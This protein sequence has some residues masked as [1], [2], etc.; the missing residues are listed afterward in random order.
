MTDPEGQPKAEGDPPPWEQPG[1]YR[2]DCTPHRGPLLIALSS[3]SFSLARV[4][5]LVCPMASR[6]HFAFSLAICG[7]IALPLGLVAWRLAVRDLALMDAK[8]MDP[9]GEEATVR[10]QQLA[11][12]GVMVG[13]VGLLPVALLLCLAH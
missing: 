9:A 13:L 7:F 1:Q 2:R 10:A 4:S 3:V 6:G 11:L 12:A 5:L 8:R